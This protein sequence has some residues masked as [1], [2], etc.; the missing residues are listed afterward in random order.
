[1]ELQRDIK[2]SEL[3][4]PQP[5]ITEPNTISYDQQMKNIMLKCNIDFENTSEFSPNDIL[6]VTGSIEHKDLEIHRL[7]ERN[8]ALKNKLA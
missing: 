3:N 8:N 6:P 7:K 2:A 1:M 5:I 4:L